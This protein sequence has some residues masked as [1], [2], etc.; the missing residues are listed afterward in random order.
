M[1]YLEQFLRYVFW[2]LLSAAAAWVAKKIF[3]AALGTNARSERAGARKRTET[4]RAKQLFRD[5]VCGTYVAE[6]ICQTL[7]G[8]G[9]IL[10]FCS[11]ECMERYQSSARC[12]D[13]QSSE[14]RRADRAAAGA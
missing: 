3:Q 13:A 1:K 2:V 5:P 14:H 9:E 10:H 8:G 12:D 11:R 4:L 7:A 6:D